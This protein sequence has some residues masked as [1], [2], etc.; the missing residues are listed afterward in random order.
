[1]I[2]TTIR[3]GDRGERVKF[4]QRLL[5]LYPDGIFGNETDA[6]VRRFQETNGLKA[7]GIVGVGTLIRL[8]GFMFLPVDRTITEII[9]H[10]TATPEGKDFTVDDIRRWHKEQGWSDIGYHYVIYRDGSIHEG[11]NVKYSGAHCTGH[12]ANSIGVVYIG[13]V[14]KDGKT[15]KDTRTKAQKRALLQVMRTLRAAYPSARIYGHRD[16]A[17]KD[18]PSFDARE[19]YKSV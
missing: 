7:D 2:K 3:K 6:A 16:F 4:V 9:V 10:C 18:C 19:E 17:K 14:S 8:C 12:N 1:M 13:G 15:A 11:R 5:N